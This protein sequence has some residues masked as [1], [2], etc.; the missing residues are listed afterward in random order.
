MKKYFYLLILALMPLCFTSC[1][2]DDNDASGSRDSQVVGTWTG[3]AKW[4]SSTTLV[5]RFESD[6]KC[7]YNEWWGSSRPEPKLFGSWSTNNGF[8]TIYEEDRNGIDEHYYRY[9]I[10]NGGRTMTFY[11]KAENGEYTEQRGVY[12]KQ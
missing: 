7:Y 10:T 8:I 1:G 12:I 5:Y 3:S 11:K 2:S 6:G 4:D 9:E